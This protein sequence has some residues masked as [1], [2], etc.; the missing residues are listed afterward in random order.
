MQVTKETLVPLGLIMTAFGLVIGGV[1]FAGKL[2]NQ[3]EINA[4]NIAEHYKMTSTLPTREEFETVVEG[5]V[6]D[7]TI[8]KGD[9][10]ILIK[11][12]NEKL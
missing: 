8:I 3:V 6:D 4:L 1:F 12:Y 11:N 9:V 7:V 10:K 2:V 5:I